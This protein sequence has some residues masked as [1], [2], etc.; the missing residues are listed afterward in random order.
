MKSI[1]QLWLNVI[2]KILL[3]NKY[4]RLTY[5]L[6]HE[7]AEN[8]LEANHTH[9]ILFDG[10]E[11]SNSK[12]R[13]HLESYI[14][15]SCNMWGVPAG[16]MQIQKSVNFIEFFR[17]LFDEDSVVGRDD[18]FENGRENVFE[19]LGYIKKRPITRY[20]LVK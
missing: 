17:Y 16:R 6:E 8:Q 7:L 15:E 12:F 10:P 1:I 13:F 18:M 9:Y 3:G 5:E 11:M 20:T 14:R 2:F 4:L 19:L